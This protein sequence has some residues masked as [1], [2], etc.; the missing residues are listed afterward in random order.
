MYDNVSDSESLVKEPE[1]TCLLS[2]VSC[3]SILAA[4]AYIFTSAL[5]F[6]E[7]FNCLSFWYISYKRRVE[8]CRAYIYY[9]RGSV[10]NFFP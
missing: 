2:R 8:I 1:H 7:I 5:H 6:I 9:I 4:C 10:D 3:R